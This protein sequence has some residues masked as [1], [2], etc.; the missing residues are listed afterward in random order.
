MLYAE[1]VVEIN[2]YDWRA[3]ILEEEYVREIEINEIAPC[4]TKPGRIRVEAQTVPKGGEPLAD[5]LPLML[6]R[7]PP[8]AAKLDERDKILTL[9]MH[10][11]M[12]GIF[13]SGIIGMQN[14]KDQDEAKVILEEIRGMLNQSYSHF[15]EKG[16]PSKDALH[17]RRNIEKRSTYQIMRSL[18]NLTH[19]RKCGEVSCSSFAFKLRSGEVNLAECEVL[20]DKRYD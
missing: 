8:G 5:L 11:R 20:K 12:I 18:P 14:T 19:C 2:K 4:F 7:F 3:R 10:D 15:F 13:A 6:L 1:F 16:G 17:K 9:R